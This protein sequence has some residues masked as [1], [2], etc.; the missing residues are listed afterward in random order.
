MGQWLPCVRGSTYLTVE[1]RIA[2]RARSTMRAMDVYGALSAVAAV[3]AAAVAV[4]AWL[5]G[6]RD[7]R[8]A[9][10]EAVAANARASEATAAA[11]RSAEAAERAAAAQEAMVEDRR[12][13][14]VLLQLVPSG[15]NGWAIQ[16]EGNAPARKVFVSTPPESSVIV[17][18]DP[19]PRGVLHPGDSVE[20]TFGNSSRGKN[21]EL[22]IH[23]TDPDGTKRE[24]RQPAPL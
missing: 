3:I 11:K 24:K 5:T 4:A 6:R 7:V 1:A 18:G 8:T 2:T 16:N 22:I 17:W 19:A 20:A 23:W 9:Q 13:S 12:R 21:R 10:A 15:V 14:V